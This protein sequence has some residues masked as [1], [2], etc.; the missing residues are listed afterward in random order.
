MKMTDEE[1]AQFDSPLLVED[2]PV[3][4]GDDIVDEWERQLQG[5]TGSDEKPWF[6]Q[7]KEVLGNEST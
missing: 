4:T 3:V 1:W 5:G 7:V 6:E 2:E